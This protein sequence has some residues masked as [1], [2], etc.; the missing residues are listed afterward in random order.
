MT[1]KEWLDRYG[2]V[3]EWLS[4]ALILLIFCWSTL[5]SNDRLL[6][7]GV[8]L[9]GTI[10]FYWWVKYC[11]VN[12][13]DPSFTDIFFHPYGKDIFAHKFAQSSTTYS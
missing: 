10:W 4:Y 5:F 3:L 13:I 9:F 12:G 11:L 8:D 7:D 2:V 1:K 6:G